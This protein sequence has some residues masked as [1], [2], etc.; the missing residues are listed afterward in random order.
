MIQWT[1]GGLGTGLGILGIGAVM[2][3]LGGVA[4]PAAAA[5]FC[6]RNATMTTPMCIYYDAAECQRE[7]TRQG[8]DCTVNR[9]EVT[10]RGGIGQYCMVTSSLVLA[11]H[12]PDRESCARDARQQNG[13]CTDSPGVA[14]ARAPDPYSRQNG[15]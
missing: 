9:R 1:W 7:A 15:Y 10:V 3:L 4:Q 13:A 8:G 12:Y 6:M 5:P 11:C 14:P 2:W